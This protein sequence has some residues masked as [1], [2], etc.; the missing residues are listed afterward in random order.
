MVYSA[1]LDDAYLPEVAAQNRS[2]RTQRC[3][4]LGQMLLD[5]DDWRNAIQGLPFLVS[6]PEA[7]EGL[8]SV[9]EDFVGALAEACNVEFDD[10]RSR[11][12]PYGRAGGIAALYGAFKLLA[13]DDT[14]RVLVGGIDSLSLPDC[15]KALDRDDAVLSLGGDRGCIPSEGAAM[16]LLES[17]ERPDDVRIHAPGLGRQADGDEEGVALSAATAAALS[18]AGRTV[19]RA[20]GTFNGQL[21]MTNEWQRAW[22]DNIKQLGDRAMPLAPGVYTGDLGAAYATTLMVLSAFVLGDEKSDHADMVWAASDG[23]YRGAAVI[24]GGSVARTD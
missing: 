16:L 21:K 2:A 6:L 22:M 18:A 14:D 4:G 20:W 17:S 9:D 5:T 11:A 8:E 1:A 24:E 13:S 15:V 12:Y 10:A 3:L 23:P 7:Q 19:G